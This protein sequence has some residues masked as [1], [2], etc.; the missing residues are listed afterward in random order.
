MLV[1]VRFFKPQ[2][3]RFERLF[4]AAPARRF[5]FA[6][7]PAFPTASLSKRVFLEFCRSRFL[8]N[9]GLIPFRSSVSAFFWI[10]RRNVAPR[11]FGTPASN[12]GYAKILRRQAPAKHDPGRPAS[13]LTFLSPVAT[14][15]S[16]SPNFNA[17]AI[18]KYESK[19]REIQKKASK[20]VDGPSP[21]PRN[22]RSK[23]AEVRPPRIRWDAKKPAEF[24]AR[25]A[26]SAFKLDA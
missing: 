16:D 8:P 15:F 2:E 1:L 26:L 24:Y 6:L 13:N 11:R 17:N 3:L 10:K 14:V 12:V 5:F 19:I 9:V 25:R 22:F 18:E 20:I 7:T 21:D 4:G 23:I